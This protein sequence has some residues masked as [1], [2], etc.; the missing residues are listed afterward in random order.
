M[1]EEVEVAETTEV[2]ETTGWGESWRQDYAGEDAS[3]LEQLGR[4]ASPNAAFDA[5]FSA[6]QKISSGEYKSA[7][8][9]PADG[10]PEDQ[11]AWRSSNGIPEAADKYELGDFGEDVQPAIDSLTSLAFENNLPA[12]AAKVAATWYLEQ[13]NAAIEAQ[14]D[15]D[16]EVRETAEDTLR[17]EWGNEYR[18]NMN[19]I[20]GLLDT[21]PE[22]IKDEILG[23]RLASGVPLGSDPSAL[24]FLVDL[25]LIQNPTTTIVPPGGDMVDS[26][27]DELASLQTLMKNPSSEYWKGPK[28]ETNQ[29]RVRELND[30]MS[31]MQK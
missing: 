8:S 14:N 16:S 7:L 4:Y 11:A 31:R 29:A 30:A 18:T 12:G 10:T 2:P 1:S 21:A 6:K 9:F 26:I 3:K 15:A 24:K 28:A 17:N 19:K 27:T 5:L 20:H 22:G 23:A 13:Q 25:A